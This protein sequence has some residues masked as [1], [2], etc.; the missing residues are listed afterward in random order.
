MIPEIST[1]DLLKLA[2]GDVLSLQVYKFQGESPWQ[3]SLYSGKSTR[4]RNC[5]QR[6]DSPALSSI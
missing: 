1:I 2:S 6:G 5:W 4:R 3:K